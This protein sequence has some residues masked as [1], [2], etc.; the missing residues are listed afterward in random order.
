M[1]LEIQSFIKLNLDSFV[2]DIFGFTYILQNDI[3]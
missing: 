3:I 1:F 2:L